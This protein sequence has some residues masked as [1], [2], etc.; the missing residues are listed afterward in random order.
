MK[1]KKDKDFITYTTSINEG[2]LANLLTDKWS[3][4]SEDLID[5]AERKFGKQLVLIDVEKK[6]NS[7][8]IYFE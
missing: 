6:N 4:T 8:I 7:I 2:D 5:E 1:W 3:H